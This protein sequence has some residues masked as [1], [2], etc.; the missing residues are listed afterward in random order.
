MKETEKLRESH[1]I[2]PNDLRHSDL[3]PKRKVAIDRETSENFVIGRG[4]INLNA[5]MP[6]F[7][8]VYTVLFIRLSEPITMDSRATVIAESEP[9]NFIKK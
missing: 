3:D 4:W 2:F 1:N 6:S 8:G 5:N 7:N 9:F